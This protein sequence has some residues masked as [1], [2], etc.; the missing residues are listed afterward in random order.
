[1]GLA[2]FVLSAISVRFVFSSV[3]SE[4]NAFWI[5]KSYP[6]ALKKFL[7]IKYTLYILPMAILGEILIIATNYLLNVTPLMMVISSVTILL[8]VSGIVSL[9]VGLGAVYPKFRHQNIAEVA[10]GFGGV[11]YMIICAVFMGLVILLEAAP[12]YMLFMA[13]VRGR[14]ITI[15]E[16]IFIVFSFVLVLISISLS[17]YL[18]LRMGAKALEE[19]E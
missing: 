19:Y 16:W 6:I 12:V 14:A 4:G 8:A 5:I 2:G 18:P 3:S 11:L 17:T 15:L 7:W 13:G 10:T 1:M 9:G